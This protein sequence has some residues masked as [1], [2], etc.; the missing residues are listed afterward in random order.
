MELNLEPKYLVVAS[1]VGFVLMVV[2]FVGYVFDPEVA[3]QAVFV[4]GVV[5]LAI[6]YAL[7]YLMNRDTMMKVR[8]VEPDEE[9]SGFF[10]ILDADYSAPVDD[11]PIID[12][13]GRDE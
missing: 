5:L 2:G 11:V 10:Y 6:G 7:L 9:R 12:L 1:L 3:Y 13:R 4:V 8:D